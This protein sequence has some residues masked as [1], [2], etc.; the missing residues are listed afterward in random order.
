MKNLF[1]FSFLAIVVASVAW[2]QRDRL[3]PL[4][5]P[6]TSK[7][8]AASQVEQTKPAKEAAAAS[9]Q[10]PTNNVVQQESA[11]GGTELSAILAAFDGV[12]K[13]KI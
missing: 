2:A 10:Q 13:E 4:V 11:M 6:L 1:L 5:L 9:V 8:V 7:I 3:V 12:F